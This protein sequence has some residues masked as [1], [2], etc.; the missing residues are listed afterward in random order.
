MHRILRS[1]VVFSVFIGA[2]SLGAQTANDILAR[3]VAAVGGKDVISQVK[4]ISM[5]T[6]THVGENDIPGT[7]VT[8]DGVASR[9]A[10]ALPPRA[11]GHDAENPIG[12]QVERQREDHARAHYPESHH[13]D[14]GGEHRDGR[15]YARGRRPWARRVPAA[16]SETGSR[17]PNPRPGRRRKSC[18]AGG[19]GEASNA[20]LRDG[21]FERAAEARQPAAL[22]PGAI[23]GSSTI[24]RKVRKYE[25]A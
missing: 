2:A 13:D 12:A 17:K 24:L 21:G 16:H 19:C 7:V 14:G 18:G 11:E 9:R 10:Q 6:I 8:L 3:H 5:E 22:K 4:S 15:P 20:E 25:A 1:I 23:S